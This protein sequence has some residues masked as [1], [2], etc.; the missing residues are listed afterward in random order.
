MIAL[1]GELG[2]VLLGR[3]VA[4]IAWDRLKGRAGAETKGDD[5]P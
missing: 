2:R 4:E 5:N 1:V 3:V